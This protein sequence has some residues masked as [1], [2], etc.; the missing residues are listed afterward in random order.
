MIHLK[1]PN[2]FNVQVPE[3][4][5]EDDTPRFDINLDGAE[6][7]KYYNNNGYVIFNNCISQNKCEIIRSTWEK[8]IKPYKGTI[9]RQ[10]TENLGNSTVY[11]PK[12]QSKLMNR[13][14]LKIE[15]NFPT[16]FYWLKKKVI[17]FLIGNS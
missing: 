3:N 12:D 1:T 17:K 4:K 9:Y 7:L 14:I 16:L 11:R 13:L 8:N 10:T 2:G 6:A 5:E 15:S